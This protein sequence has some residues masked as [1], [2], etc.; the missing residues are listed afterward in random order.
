MLGITP[1]AAASV[2]LSP[3]SASAVSGGKGE[4][5]RKKAVFFNCNSIPLVDAFGPNRANVWHWPG[6]TS[7]RP[8]DGEDFSSQGDDDG[9]DDV[10]GEEE[11]ALLL[12]L[13]LS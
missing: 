8:L 7:D 9:D 2:V 13:S 11:S 1:L 6:G 4:K 10:D 3:L 5:E 12:L